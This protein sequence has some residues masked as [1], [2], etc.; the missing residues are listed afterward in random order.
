MTHTPLQGDTAGGAAA[1]PAE[2]SFL[3]HHTL[4]LAAAMMG[5]IAAQEIATA[6]EG[7]QGLPDTVGMILVQ[8]IGT[9]LCGLPLIA[10]GLALGEREGLRL[11]LVA[12]PT[13]RDGAGGA[14]PWP[15]S[16][17]FSFSTSS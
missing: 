6:L 17:G 8:W 5:V 4:I 16:T 12:Q 1:P 10:L 14:M 7:S 11:K 15:Y 3:W 9:I 2:R 13:P